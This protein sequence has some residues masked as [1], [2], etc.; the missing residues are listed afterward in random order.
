MGRAEHEA[1]VASVSASAPGAWHPPPYPPGPHRAPR[2]RQGAIAQ[3]VQL[4]GDH[5]GLKQRGASGRYR[6]PPLDAMG[7][8]F[9]RPESPPWH[10]GWAPP[11]AAG[12]P[13]SARSPVPST[14][15]WASPAYRRASAGP[16]PGLLFHQA[17]DDTQ[18]RRSSRHRPGRE[19]CRAPFEALPQ[20]PG[21]IITVVLQAGVAGGVPEPQWSMP[22]RM[23]PAARG[24]TA[25]SRPMPPGALADL[26]RA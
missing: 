20:A 6:Q 7:H 2:H 19:R 25:P 15:S 3:A 8:G 12:T 17:A 10:Q 22:L 21:G 9:I 18:Q 23:P 4:V 26:G 24:G 13:H 14:T 1:P 5:P 11:R 16:A